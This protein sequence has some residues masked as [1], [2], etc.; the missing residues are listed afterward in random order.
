MQ[1]ATL[2]EMK[3][4]GY[5]YQPALRFIEDMIEKDIPLSAID[6]NDWHSSPNVIVYLTI[7]YGSSKKGGK[8]KQWKNRF[9]KSTLKSALAFW[10]SRN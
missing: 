1:K 7:P 5:Y 10:E 3:K 6:I 4:S 2:K 8:S 9:G